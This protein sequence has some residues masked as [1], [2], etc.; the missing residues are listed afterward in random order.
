[1]AACGRGSHAAVLI[2]GILCYSERLEDT[3]PA[4]FVVGQHLR[5][6]V[7]PDG[8]IVRIVDHDGLADDVHRIHETDIAAVQGLVAVVAEDEI[9]SSR[10]DDFSMDNVSEHCLRGRKQA[11]G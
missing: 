3:V 2:T 11:P 10:Y 4:G 8:L 9:L 6:R 5:L 7:W 1:M